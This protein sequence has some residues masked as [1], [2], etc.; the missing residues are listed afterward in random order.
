MLVH[1]LLLRFKT[2]NYFKTE[3]LDARKGKNTG[4]ATGL[5]GVFNGA[6]RRGGNPPVLPGEDKK[7][8]QKK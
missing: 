7:V 3:I 2:A 4:Y 8:E 6:F 1:G 5:S